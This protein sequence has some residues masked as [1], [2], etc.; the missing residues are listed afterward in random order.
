MTSLYS[1]LQRIKEKIQ[2][3]QIITES[4][5]PII[6]LSKTKKNNERIL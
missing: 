3:T 2:V 4:G 1:D 6:Y 5:D